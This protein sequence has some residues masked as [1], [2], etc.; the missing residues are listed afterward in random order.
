LFIDRPVRVGEICE[1]QGI[2]GGV[3]NIGLRS[4][5]IRTFD[6]RLV[7]VPNV[8]FSTSEITNYSRNRG[9]VLN[10]TLGLVYD[11]TTNQLNQILNELRDYLDTH[12]GVISQRVRLVDLGDFS[13]NIGVKVVLESKDVNQFF[14]FQEEFLFKSMAIVTSAGSDFAY[15]SQTIY[16]DQQ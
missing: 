15:P 3:E 5:R 12:E 2:T 7:T 8:I 6:N 9:Q 14:Y 16:M 11:T 10:K 4:T 13:L 1:F